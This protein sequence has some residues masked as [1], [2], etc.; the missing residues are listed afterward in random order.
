M[1][2]TEPAYVSWPCYAE[3]SVSVDIMCLLSFGLFPSRLDVETEAVLVVIYHPNIVDQSIPSWPT[4]NPVSAMP[5]ARK[6]SSDVLVPLVADN[7][8]QN[9]A[10]GLIEVARVLL[11]FQEVLEP[12]FPVGSGAEPVNAK[13]V[14][15]M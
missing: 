13:C 14:N 12:Q 11:Q 2:T 15:Q 4:G 9:P 7:P 1:G 6:L 3:L 10:R 5:H 8:P